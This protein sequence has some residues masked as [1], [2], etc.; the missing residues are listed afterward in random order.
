MTLAFDPHAFARDLASL[1]Y[2]KIPVRVG[3]TETY[4]TIQERSAESAL[5]SARRWAH[6]QPWTIVDGATA[7]VHPNFRHDGTSGCDVCNPKARELAHV[8][9]VDDAEIEQLGEVVSDIAQHNIEILE[10]EHV[11]SVER[12]A[13]LDDRAVPVTKR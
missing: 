2:W 6:V 5:E 9:P 1:H 4:V 3:T 11:T 7:V 8:G 13:S 12:R 10:P